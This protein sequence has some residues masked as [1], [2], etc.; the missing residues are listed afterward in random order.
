MI[1]QTG[2]NIIVGFTA[3]IVVG[4]LAWVGI[5]ETVVSGKFKL[6]R[7]GIRK[8]LDVSKVQ[9]K[10]H[11]K[12]FE[13][14]QRVYKE[15]NKEFMEHLNKYEDFLNSKP[16]INKEFY[17]KNISE[18]TIMYY[19][20]K[21]QKKYNQ[22]KMTTSAYFDVIL[23]KLYIKLMRG[24]YI[25]NIYHELSHLSSYFK[26]GDIAYHGFRQMDTNTGY[27]IGV[28]INE[29][30]TEIINRTYFEKDSDSYEVAYTAVERLSKIIGLEKMET[31]Y[32]NADLKGLVDEIMKCGVSKE[33]VY[34][35]IINLDLY[36]KI[37][38]EYKKNSKYTINALIKCEDELNKFLTKLYVSKK[39]IDNPTISDSD[40]KNDTIDFADGYFFRSITVG[41]GKKYPLSIRGKKFDITTNEQIKK[42]IDDAIDEVKHKDVA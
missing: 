17:N 24:K 14:V 13:K 19:D 2:V 18:V 36:Y 29:G 10:D 42:Y 23:G 27:S 30:F 6:Q 22:G 35:F 28:G 12:V 31:L 25:K 34:K 38:Y 20:N 41:S 39:T 1:D 4:G 40:L 32:F 33:E 11:E 3:P 5:Y 37:E 21:T 15:E 7:R 26:K 16:H 8:T 9:I